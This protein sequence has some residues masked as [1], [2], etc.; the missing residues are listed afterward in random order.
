VEK[1][2]S[3]KGLA[4]VALGVLVFLLVASIALV[5][6]WA[7]QLSTEL[8]TTQQELSTLQAE[9][10]KLQEEYQT[11]SSEKDQLAKDLEKANTDLA[12]TKSDL[13]TAQQKSS[14][15]TSKINKASK[16]YGVVY[17][18]VTSDD[19]SDVFDLNASIE[20][21][22]DQ[23]LINKWNALKAAPSDDGFDAFLDYLLTATRDSLK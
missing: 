9:H 21:S 5:G 19:V 16:L 18:W 7:Y 4:G 2:R 20:E 3:R 1:K 23:N 8:T 14:N 22:G 13:S 15:L 10:Q 6:Y 12:T 17:L 11:L